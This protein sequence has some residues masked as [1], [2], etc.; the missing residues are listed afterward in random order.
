MKKRVIAMAS[1]LSLLISPKAFAFGSNVDVDPQQYSYERERSE[2]DWARLRD[3]RIEWGEIQ[4]LVREYNPTVSALWLSYREQE[5][6]GLYNVDY[7]EALSAIE[8]QYEAQLSAAGASGDDNAQNVAVTIADMQYQLN[9]SRTL[10]DSSAQSTDSQAARIQVMQSEK[11]MA[12]SLKKSMITLYRTEAEA[13]LLEKGIVQQ[14]SGYEQTERRKSVGSATQIDLL[15][16]KENLDNAVLSE[17]T[18]KDNLTKLRQLLQVSL[19]WGYDAN[20]EMDAIPMPSAEE[21]D[22]LNVD[23]DTK[24]ALQ[25]SYGIRITERKMAVSE[26]DTQIDQLSLT[27]ENQKQSVRSDMRSRYQAV[28]QSRNALTQAGLTEENARA[29]YEKAERS[30]QVGGISQRELEAA[31]YARDSAET[32]RVLA[33][34]SLA[35]AYYDYLAGRDGIAST[36]AG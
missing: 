36:S 23:T 33:E 18:A 16:A 22:S 6:N 7:T 29:A 21:L 31:E 4:D 11:T 15:T 1:L 35:S 26:T 34:Y 32:G 20:P 30:Y 8:E 2:E 27:L 24:L 25:N 9:T 19:G 12:E 3:N 28:Q 17:K 5:R 13:K 14:R 10:V